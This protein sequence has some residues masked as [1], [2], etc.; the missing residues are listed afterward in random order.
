MRA[1]ISTII[2]CMRSTKLTQTQS[3][4][5]LYGAWGALPDEVERTLVQRGVESSTLSTEHLPPKLVTVY[6]VPHVQKY[7]PDGQRSW[8]RFMDSFHRLVGKFYRGRSNRA[9]AQGV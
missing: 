2:S 1:S 9:D 8:L 4:W 5:R 3:Q 6:A 7:R